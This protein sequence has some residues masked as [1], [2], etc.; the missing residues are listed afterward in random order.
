MLE[1]IDCDSRTLCAMV[2]IP[3]FDP[4]GANSREAQSTA[5]GRVAHLSSAHEVPGLATRVLSAAI[6]RQAL[7]GDGV[8]GARVAND[9]AAHHHVGR[10]GVDTDIAVATVGVAL[11]HTQVEVLEHIALDRRLAAKGGDAKG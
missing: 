2:E 5:K 3:R 10:L 9:I 7:D 8:A 1:G 11:R 4:S 6:A